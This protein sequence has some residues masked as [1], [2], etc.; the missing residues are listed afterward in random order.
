MG[1]G[2]YWENKRWQGYVVSA[3]CDHKGCREIIDRGMGYQHEEDDGEP[4]E[5][6]CCSKHQEVP[7]KDFPYE[8]KE[9][10]EWLKLVLTNE[11]WGPWRID[12]PDIVKEYEKMLEDD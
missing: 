1:Y 10:P 12:N 11:S 8:S 5:I 2:V 7:V 6:F 9:A 4:G 3:Y